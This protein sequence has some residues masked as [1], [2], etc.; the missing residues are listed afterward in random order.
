MNTIAEDIL[1]HIGMPKRSGRYPYGS[2]KDPYQRSIDFLGRVEELKKKGW[3][4][5]PENIM[6]EFGLSTTEYRQ[7]KSLAKTERNR[8][9]VAQ[10]ESLMKDGISQTEACRRAGV[11]ESTYRSMKEEKVVAR[12][13]KAQETAKFLMDV[14]DKQGMTDVGKGTET[15][16]NISRE[17]LQSALKICEEK[18]Y[19]VYNN[20]FE[21][22][23]N[24]GKFTTQTVLCPPH[25][26]PKGDAK[27]PSEI[28]DL[29]NVHSLKPYISRDGGETFEKK[30]TYPASMDSKRL[31]IRYNEEGGV[32]KDGIV[33][34]R[35]GVDDLSLGN[36]KYAQVRILVDDTH[37]IKGMA[38]YTDGKDMPPGVDVVFNT[39]KKKGL[40]MTDV[41][42][43]IKDDPENP[44]G[45]LIKD[46]DQG[47]QYWYTDKNGQK[48]LGLINK[49]ADEGDWTEWQDSLPSQFLS[50]Q[51][52]QMVRKQLDLA[53]QDKQYEYEEICKINNPTIKKHMLAKFA[54][55]CDSAAEHLKAAALPGQ[56]YHVIIPI[57][58]LKD[59]EIYAP[60]YEPGTQL[61]LVRYPHGG[62]FEIP[63]V[64]VT[65]KNPTARKIIGTDSIDAVGINAKV[66]SQLSGADFDG[67]T[68]M[69]IPTNTKGVKVKATRPLDELKDFDTGEYQY[70]KMV[71]DKD[72]NPHYYNKN[73]DEFK[74]M[75]KKTEGIEMG[76]ITNLITDMTLAGA[77]DDEV[78]RAVRHSMVVIDARKHC[79]DYRQSEHDNDIASLRREYQVKIGPDGKP[80]YGA[81]GTII[82]RAKNQTEVPKTQ[83]SPHTNM[84]GKPWYD[85]S[86]PEGAVVYSKAD[87]PTYTKVD[88]RTGKT[89]VK[90]KTEKTTQMRATDDA[91]TLVSEAR[92]PKELLY[93][94]YAN[95]MKALANKARL[96]VETAGKIATSPTA[97]KIYAD[98][99][100]SLR[101]KVDT[102]MVNK[103]RERAAQRMARVDIQKAEKRYRDKGEE[104]DKEE[105]RKLGQ[106]AIGKYRDQV[107]SVKR[108]DRDIEITDREWEAIQAGAVSETL[109][110]TILDN[111]DAGKLR[112]R[113]TP[114]K[115]TGLTSAQVSRVKSLS[116]KGYSLA[117]IAKKLGVS[118]STVHKYLKGND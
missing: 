40:P 21:Q 44:F 88:K 22:V 100:K 118:T 14:V 6:K 94:D 20:R 73:G 93:A 43:E 55:E 28:Y 31:K 102:A 89:I 91:Y 99:V 75:S 69:V 35:R 13:E 109:L 47:G 34:I 101:E 5:T 65:D 105:I 84:K 42:K 46:A 110:K 53:K 38:V 54:D 98:E 33:E 11:K 85:P 56:K 7:E 60:G 18:G 48:K 64:T 45:S 51:P 70:S 4:E 72:G 66:A 3:T 16:L 9:R 32:E 39:N 67:D 1:A 59:N 58:S 12:R 112:D 52:I 106:R 49:R 116:A 29:E 86:R 19:G 79:L 68:V 2:G 78:A 83:G 26:K 80:K 63:I 82:S 113:A 61:A 92:H 103:P 97:K 10:V 36:S 17:K 111:T 114:K 104:V 50:K 62:T 57:T 81:A 24:P 77:P 8:Y 15:E 25:I 107:G 96:D 76:R 71:P 74:R 95:T 115:T 117:E 108:S 37:Y 30:F 87:E 23:N 41:L 27:A 90:E